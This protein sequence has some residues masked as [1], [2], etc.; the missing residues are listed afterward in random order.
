[1]TY[2]LC[3][4]PKVLTLVRM[5]CSFR[6]RCIFPTEF[7]A[8]LWAPG[9]MSNRRAYLVALT[10]E[11]KSSH[12][13]VIAANLQSSSP[14]LFLQVICFHLSH[15]THL[16]SHSVSAFASVS[17]KNWVGWGCLWAARPWKHKVVAMNGWMPEGWS[18]GACLHDCSYFWKEQT[19]TPTF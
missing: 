2:N 16:S 8:K 3:L 4:F 1:M 7:L 10:I 9:K 14:F 19:A 17:S 6:K 15:N 13:L 11:W 5:S 12:L 18:G